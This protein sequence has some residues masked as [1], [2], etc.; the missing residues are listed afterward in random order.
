MTSFAEIAHSVFNSPTT[1]RPGRLLRSLPDIVRRILP[2][3]R[4]SP[5]LETPVAGSHPSSAS[6]HKM[7]PSPSQDEVPFKNSTTH[8][9]ACSLHTGIWP[10]LHTLCSRP[11]D[12]VFRIL[13]KPHGKFAWMNGQTIKDVRVLKWL[14]EGVMSSA[15]LKSGNVGIPHRDGGRSVTFHFVCKTWDI[16]KMGQWNGFYSELALYKSSRYLLPLQGDVVPHVMGVYTHPGKIDIVMDLPHPVFW[17]EASA[18]MPIVLKDRVVEA[19]QKLHEKGVVH[20]DVALR[21]IL[22]GADARVTLI[23]FQASRADEPNEDLGLAATSPGEKDLEMRRVKFLLNIGNARKK[24]F[25]KSRAAL[26]RSAL[27]KA[28]EQRRR[29]LLQHGITTSLPLDEPEPLEDIRVPPVPLDELEK[30]W[31]E[32]AND[33]P[34]RFVVPGSSDSDVARAIVSFLQC[35]RDMERADCGWSD[36]CNGPSSPRSPLASP[37]LSPRL[38][39]VSIPGLPQS[40]KVRDFA[41]ESTCWPSISRLQ[42]EHHLD[43]EDHGPSLSPSVEKE[44]GSNS[45]DMSITLS[46]SPNHLKRHHEDGEDNATYVERLPTGKKA[47]LD[48]SPWKECNTTA[49]AEAKIASDC[50]LVRMHSEGL[51]TISPPISADGCQGSSPVNEPEAERPRPKRLREA[52]EMSDID[53]GVNAKKLRGMSQS[54]PPYHA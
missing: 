4:Y 26:K 52:V 2:R 28:R 3:V 51:E 31:M 1:G 46:H 40:I 11:D 50:G 15:H 18:S 36:I 53:E 25:R 29:E 54:G 39:E 32:D 21:H 24:E 22:I 45:G 41:Y 13:Y 30:Y 16:S 27:N 49:T 14:G 10:Q 43:M 48:F 17:M 23:D 5:S 20:G 44:E 8:G 42:A 9:K 12:L 19:F 47:R 33:D 6:A 7:P 37:S 34:R 38:D 35:I